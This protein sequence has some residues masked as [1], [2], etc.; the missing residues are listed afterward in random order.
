MTDNKELR[1]R[2]RLF[3][4]IL[5]TVLHNQ[6][7][8]RV[9]EAVET[10][11][12][13]YIELQEGENT[14]K[15]EQ[16]CQVISQL[17][18]QTLTHVVRAFSIYFGLVNVAEE[19]Y[20]HRQRRNQVRAGGTLWSGSFDATLREF[21]VQGISA[22]QLQT[23]LNELSYTPVIT[24]H[25]TESRRQ[26]I[27]AAMRRIFVTSEQLDDP[28]VDDYGRKA[29]ERQLETQVQVLWKTD[30]V[31][32][33]RLR[34]KD[35]LKNGI[36]YFENS[37]FEAVCTTYRYLEKGIT[38]VYGEGSNRE[39][40]ITVPSFIHFGSWIGGDRDGNPNVTPDTTVYALRYQSTVILREYIERIRKLSRI[41]SHSSRMCTPSAALMTSLET[42]APCATI[43]FHDNLERFKNEPYRR[44]LYIM[45][46]RLQCNL[47]RLEKR[48]NGESADELC[49]YEYSTEQDYLDDLYLIRDSLI[50]HD[51]KDIADGDFKD[52]IRLSETFGFFL[53]HLDIRQESGRH[54]DAVAE[55][56]AHHN[57]AMNYREM[58]ETQRMQLLTT[59]IDKEPIVGDK[60]LLSA[61]TQ[62]TLAVFEVMATMRSEISPQ[63]FGH[64][65][66]SMT[67]EASHVMEVM[68]LARQ[69]G[70]L[71]R[72]NGARFCNIRISPLFETIEDLGHIEPVMAT[73]LDNPVYAELLG[74]SDQMQE[75]MLGYSD[76]CKDGGILS[77]AWSLY[78]AQKKI[79]ALTEAK[80]VKCCLFH[81]RGGTI[82]RGGGPTH[83]AILSQPEGTVLGQIKFTEQGEM[84]SAKYSN[85]ETAVY[86][87]SVGISGLIKASKG[88]VVEGVTQQDEYQSIMSKL[89][90]IGEQEYRDL[91]DHT[92][93]FFDYF[94]EATP[95]NE[96]GMLNIGSRPSHR[97]KADR[98][99]SSIRAI[100]WVFGWAQSRHTLPA[101][102]GIGSALEQWSKEDPDHLDKL[103]AMY[104]EW[105]FFRALLS[106]TQ[107]ALFKANMT[108]ASEYAKLSTNPEQAHSIHQ[109]I[110]EECCRTREQISHI[111]G[112]DL[113]EE[114]PTLVFA[115]KR[116]DPYLDPLNHIQITLIKRCRDEAMTE[117]ERE[118][119]RDP[120][121]RT[122][123]AI[124]AGMRNTG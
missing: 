6:A 50:S 81:G 86:E 14:D 30:E 28:R 123:N 94:Y 82:G 36:F 58:D 62:E 121:L 70:L 64:Y 51:D 124:A 74:A 57:S 117:A 71:G 23:L 31:R 80:G 116:R 12:T 88:M 46:Q 105:P 119:W 103:Q 101:W 11:R 35:E 89:A 24:A 43:A 38:K 107:M 18:P 37:L 87:L 122:I 1:E 48:M 106:N 40:N 3:G 111:I 44:K 32:S 67:H 69:S 96:I 73:L 76:S 15:R 109:R 55:L 113:L 54:T 53:L 25:P 115:L 108:I 97:N 65:V 61:T 83:E 56:V 34:V 120:L 39:H 22:E 84:I 29:L 95:V 78:E 98:S 21:R 118:E 26:T 68:L 77:S 19:A 92:P 20:Q 7:G 5:G 66:I 110:S 2:V 27:M 112:H 4:N 63:A 60:S 102:H 42:D 47:E 75:V 114:D 8:G 16:L 91:T 100:P 33:Q 79:I 59:L 85:T 93:G 45:R 17:D 10:L 99:K 104:K 49:R 41:L 13:G 90:Q 72:H 52:L 9:F